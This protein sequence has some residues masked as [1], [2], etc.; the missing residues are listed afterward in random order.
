[1]RFT[2][3]MVQTITIIEQNKAQSARLDGL[4]VEKHPMGSD[5]DSHHTA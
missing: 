5:D 3:K 2:F 4:T 1:M